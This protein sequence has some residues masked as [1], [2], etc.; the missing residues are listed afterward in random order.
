MIPS[1]PKGQADAFEILARSLPE[2]IRARA[3]NPRILPKVPNQ[4]GGITKNVAIH[5]GVEICSIFLLELDGETPRLVLAEAYGYDDAAVGEPKWLDKGLTPMIAGLT[6]FKGPTEVI[7]NFTVQDHEGW[8]GQLD[9]ELRGHGW[10]LLGIPIVGANGKSKGVIKLENRK[11]TSHSDQVSTFLGA[12]A[13]LKNTPGEIAREA[14]I[15]TSSARRI[16]TTLTGNRFRSID[17]DRV[18]KLLDEI[19]KIAQNLADA[20]KQLS[21]DIPFGTGDQDQA[22]P[23][24][25]LAENAQ[26]QIMT[27]LQLQT[28]ALIEALRYLEDS[29]LMAELELEKSLSNVR[30]MTASFELALRAYKP[31]A[32]SDVMLVRAVAALIAA[33]IDISE[34]TGEVALHQLQH[35]LKGETVEFLGVLDKLTNDARAMWQENSAIRDHLKELWQTGLNISGP[36]DAIGRSFARSAPH[37]STIHSLIDDDIDNRA[38]FYKDCADV[39]GKSFIHRKPKADERKRLS[40][41]SLPCPASLILGVCDILFCNAA[42]HGGQNIQLYYVLD[43]DLFQVVCRDDGPGFEAQRLRDI[44]ESTSPLS[45]SARFGLS[46][47]KQA[48]S[49]FQIQLTVLKPPVGKSMENQTEVAVQIHLKSQEGDHYNENQGATR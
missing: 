31:F 33:A 3:A 9:K 11:S 24:D 20:C 41:V 32:R 18:P 12:T 48:L 1:T 27:A 16:A 29:P 19:D 37:H 42:K 22:M 10:T 45:G 7:C 14:H 13:A 30:R 23:S 4:M 43:R 28:A 47:A 17:P 40:N 49:K 34:N 26:D 5:L 15:V 2:M 36:Q 38:R 39:W 6:N 35:G 44:E 21:S 46:A 8:A 25:L